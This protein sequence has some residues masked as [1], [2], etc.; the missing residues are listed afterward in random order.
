VKKFAALL[1]TM[2]LLLLA[3]APVSAAKPE[4]FYDREV[5]WY[6]F[7]GTCE[8]PDFEVWDHVVGHE[9]ERLFY[10]NR[11]NLVKTIYHMNATDNLYDP[12]NPDRTLSGPT[13]YSVYVEITGG[14]PDHYTWTRTW[15]GTFWNLQLPGGSVFHQSGQ[16][17][18][19]VDNWVVT[20]TFWKG[21]RA[22]I[23]TEKICSAL[24]P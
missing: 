5:D 10:D 8:S 4:L 15:T 6:F 9:S 13:G 12:A 2:Q 11:G 23:D 24:A 17:I 20:D 7:L 14:E 22:V 16:F 21:G 3:V 18:E 19:Q 1:L